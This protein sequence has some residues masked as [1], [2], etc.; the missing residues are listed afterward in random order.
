M[1]KRNVLNTPRIQEL[2][3]K[4]RKVFITRALVLLVIFLALIAILFYVSR[5]NR[6]NINEVR[7]EGNK[8]IDTDQIQAS[9]QKEIDGKYLWLLPKSNILLYPKGNIRANL[10]NEFK[11]LKDIAVSLEN[12]Q[13]LLVSVSERTPEYTWCGDMPVQNDE[14]ETCYFL[15]KDGYIFD[16]AP[17]FS[18]EVY[19]KFYGKASVGTYFFEP[20][21]AKLILFKDTVLGMDLKPVVLHVDEGGDIK[22]FLSRGPQIIFKQDAD[23][24]RVAENLKAAI[25][26]EPLLSKLKNTYS[27]L[28]YIDLRF[29]NKVYFK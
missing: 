23:F 15:D 12:G 25:E 29:G 14:K 22:V 11:R 26:T 24:A 27:T 5:I 6:L 3:K 4:K 10:G 1:L 2:K 21:F 9:V 20:N 19:F 28:E 13:T 16:E 17:Y 18:G 8:V 7:V